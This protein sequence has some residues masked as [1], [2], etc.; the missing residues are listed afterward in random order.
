MIEAIQNKIKK[1]MMKLEN[2][3]YYVKSFEL[4]NDWRLIIGLGGSHPQET[5]MSLHH[6]YGIPYIPGTAIKGVTRHW[7]LMEYFNKNEA[8]ALKDNN[9]TEIF[10]TQE[11]AGN[12]VFYDA[13]PTKKINLRM[14]VMTPHHSDYYSKG[15]VPTDMEKPI[16][17]EFLT[18]ENTNFTFFLS[19][20]EEQLLNKSVTW[21]KEALQNYGIGAKTSVG[22]GYF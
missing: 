8:S 9:Y 7:C 11:K 10:G 1:N 17:I 22:Y 18:I 4:T 20:K 16:P 13:L 2:E 3:G 12:V 5:S 6:I 19:S 14:D 15:K 21:V